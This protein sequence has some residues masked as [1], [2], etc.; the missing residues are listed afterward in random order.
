MCVRACVWDSGCKGGCDRCACVCGG[1]GTSA[2]MGGEVSSK[3]RVE[4][5]TLHDA[6]GGNGAGP[7]ITMQQI[8]RLATVR[9]TDRCRR[10]GTCRAAAETCR[11][12]SPIFC[13]RAYAVSYFEPQ[14]MFRSFARYPPLRLSAE[15]LQCVCVRGRLN[16]WR[17][18]VHTDR[19]NE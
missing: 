15:S 11:R 16:V 8:L 13:Y 2:S 14:L 7:T 5:S 12:H 9:R 1:E 18:R 19:V 17:A 3:L 6:A 10:G 4:K